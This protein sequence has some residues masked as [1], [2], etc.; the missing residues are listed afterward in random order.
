MK[1]LLAGLAVTALSHCMLD[2]EEEV[3][4]LLPPPPVLWQAAFPRLC[5]KVV[6]LDAHNTVR[7]ARVEDW[8][9][10]VSVTCA[11]S[12]HTPLLAFPEESS[13]PGLRPAGGFYPD[14]FRAFQGGQ[15]LELT[16]EEGPAALVLSQ[17]ALLGRDVS[18]FNI[19][20]L[21]R[22]L[23]EQG[24]PWSVD[25]ADIADKISRE[26]LTA[27]DIDRLPCRDAELQTGPG[28]WF[29]ESPF[30]A[31]VAAEGGWTRLAGVSL[32]S[33]RLYSLSG[34]SWKVEVGPQEAAMV[35]AP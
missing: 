10:P 15:I 7:E 30:A 23:L 2:R 13:A 16:W 25:L 22:Y 17:V 12:P 35:R 1:L 4:V 21:C 34:A 8:R 31:A 24:D 9:K 26:A 19:T 5:F 29:L 28:T 14:S 33:H 18:L 20:R 6:T 3:M 32:G 27:W 11:R